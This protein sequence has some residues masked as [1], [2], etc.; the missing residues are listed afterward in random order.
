MKKFTIILSFLTIFSCTSKDVVV[1][2]IPFLHEN[3]NAQPSL[4]SGEGSLSLSWISSN[5]GKKSTL[6]FSQFKEGKWI[7]TQTMA[8]G[9]D[10][11]VNWADFP[12]HAINENLILSSYLKKSD[13]GTYTYDVILSLQKLS[14]EKVK[15]DFLLHTDGVKA[16]HGFVSII[17]NHNQGFFITWLDGRNTVDKDLGGHHKP[18]TIR[19]AEITNKGDIIDENE[20]DSATCDCCQTSIAVTNNGPVVVYRDRSEKEVRDIYIVRKTNGIWDDPIPVHNDGWE[21]NGCPVNGPK[22]ASNSNNLAVSWFTV[23]SENPTVNLS[24]SKSNGASFGTPIKINDEDAI[25]RVDVAFLNPQEVLVSYIEGDDVGTY[26]RIKKVSIDGKVS[27]PITISKID[28]GRNTGVPQLEILDNE[29]FIVWTVFEGE[30]NQL[31][32]VKLSFKNT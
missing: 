7:N 19:F 15:E 4:V 30:K 25:G 27:A 22:V 1:K 28:G 24:F 6:N 12:A 13:S 8:T 26:L 16:E 32:T 2:E 23:S 31:K 18:M 3:S 17:P 11:F 5:E 10:W 21:I 9:S 29:A 20:L 14:G